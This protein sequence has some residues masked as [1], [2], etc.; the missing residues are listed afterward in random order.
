MS[1]EVVV[2]T[3]HKAKGREWPT[4]RIPGDFEPKPGNKQKNMDQSDDSLPDIN[5]EEARLNRAEVA[6]LP[7][8]D[9]L[10]PVALRFGSDSRSLY[11]GYTSDDLYMPE[12]LV[13]RRWDRD[14]WFGLS[15]LLKQGSTVTLLRGRT[16]LPQAWRI[17][18]DGRPESA[19]PQAWLRR[20]CALVTDAS[21]GHM[22][23]GGDGRGF[24]VNTSACGGRSAPFGGLEQCQHRAGIAHRGVALPQVQRRLGDDPLGVREP[25]RPVG[26][27]QQGV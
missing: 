13:T 6:R 23:S 3:A 15:A 27:T 24:S 2:V 25:V 18:P 1:Q 9:G 8:P 11:I 19:D 16:D 4:V 12:P 20:V 7:T 10:W 26:Q 14:R 5:L 22:L 17:S 21:L